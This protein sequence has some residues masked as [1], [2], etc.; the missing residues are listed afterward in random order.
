[1]D[2]IL[3]SVL[4]SQMVQFVFCKRLT[5]PV[6][7]WLLEY[8]YKHKLYYLNSISIADEI[9]RIDELI[10]VIINCAIQCAVFTGSVLRLLQTGWIL[11]Q[12]Y[13]RSDLSLLHELLTA[14]TKTGLTREHTHCRNYTGWSK[15]VRPLSLKAQIFACP[16]LQNAWTCMI[17]FMNMESTDVFRI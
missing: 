11:I 4:C 3:F 15:K 10:L 14:S 16:H 9:K 1:L 2:S 17:N 7:I 6:V 5:L 8:E 12:F 13:V